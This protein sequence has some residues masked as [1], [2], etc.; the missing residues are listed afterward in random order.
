MENFSKKIR[1]TIRFVI[2]RSWKSLSDN[3]FL[4]HLRESIVKPSEILEKAK[5][6][7]KKLQ[8]FQVFF[9]KIDKFWIFPQF[10][11]IQFTLM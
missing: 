10:S 6:F 8:K 11:L 2:I 1:K 9:E 7:G 4:N 3:L 5:I